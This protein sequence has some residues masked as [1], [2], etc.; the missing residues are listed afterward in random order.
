MANGMNKEK[1]IQIAKI[2]KALIELNKVAKILDSFL[3]VFLNK[4][5]PKKD[6]IWLHGSFNL[7]SV[8]SGRL[9]SNGPNLQQIPSSGT[10]YAK[11]IK[12]CFTAPEEWLMVGADFNALEARIGGLITK[13]PAKLAVYL[14]GYDSHSFNAFGYWPEKM[15]DIQCWLSKVKTVDKIYSVTYNDGT[16]DYLT[17]EEYEKFN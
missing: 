6:R 15:P 13:D 10:V 17:E 4:T 3:P 9:S 8:V 5:I 11:P 7:G 16:A 1:G 14:H 12:E 2:L